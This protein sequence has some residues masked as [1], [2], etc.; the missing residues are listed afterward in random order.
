MK[1]TMQIQSVLG[2]NKVNFQHLCAVENS[3]GGNKSSQTIVAYVVTR[4]T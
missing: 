3:A 4:K 1:Q 2:L